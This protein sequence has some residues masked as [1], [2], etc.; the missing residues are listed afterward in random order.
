VTAAAADCGAGPLAC[1]SGSSR[2]SMTSSAT[3]VITI[4]TT[5]EIAAIRRRRTLARYPLQARRHRVN[6]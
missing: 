6:G 5:T 1:G 2:G 4:I 3:I